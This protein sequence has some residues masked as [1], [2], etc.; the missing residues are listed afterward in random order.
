[1]SLGEEGVEREEAEAELRPDKNLQV[2]SGRIEEY[3]GFMALHELATLLQA[4][5]STHTRVS[6][7]QF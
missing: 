2:N 3:F 1:M 4:A 5:T 6:G 7:E